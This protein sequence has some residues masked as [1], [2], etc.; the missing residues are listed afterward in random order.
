MV[1]IRLKQFRKLAKR[2]EAKDLA[3]VEHRREHWRFMK[4]IETVG[5]HDNEEVE[6]VGELLGMYSGTSS[7]CSLT[8]CLWLKD[9][10][11]WLKTFVA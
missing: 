2:G 11:L 4:T 3:D 9:L 5:S 10:K 6:T 1:Q 7:S 8:S